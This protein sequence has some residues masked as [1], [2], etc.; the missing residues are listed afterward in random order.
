MAPL[1][2]AR[3]LI[4]GGA[5][6]LGK[7]ELIGNTQTITSNQAAV[8]FTSLQESTY[9]V[10]LLTI[11]R[12]KPSVD[13]K[14]IEIAVSN[15]GGSGYEGSNYDWA[16]MYMKGNGTFSEKNNTSGGD[17]TIVQNVGY[18]TSEHFSAYVYLYNLGS[19]SKYSYATWHGTGI[20]QDPDYISTFGSGVYHVAETINALQ[21]KFSSDNIASG[22]FSLYGIKE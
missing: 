6:D 9:N 12:M 10:H 4:T 22:I 5:L 15:D 1:G 18:D 11:A 2:A 19:S 20:T 3:A 21:I 16:W 13:N 7:L 17:F 8:E 14:A